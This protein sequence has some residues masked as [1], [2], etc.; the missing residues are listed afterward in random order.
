M[1]EIEKLTR[2]I[3]N[4]KLKE[5]KETIKSLNNWEHIFISKT[6]KIHKK[7]KAL[8]ENINTITTSLLKEDKLDL[9]TLTK[10]K[11]L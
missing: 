10:E 2:I 7:T 3:V 4:D 11:T 6:N 5:I 1:D 8:S 9:K